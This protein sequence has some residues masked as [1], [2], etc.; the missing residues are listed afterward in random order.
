MAEDWRAGLAGLDLTRGS[1]VTVLTG[2][3]ISA[4]SGIPTFR[5]RDGLWKNYRAEELAT[6]EAFAA[7]PRLV[8][9]WYDWRRGIIA[10]KEPNPAHYAI[11]DLEKVFERFLLITQNVDGLHRRAGT[12][13]IVELHGYIFGVR[14]V[15][16]GKTMENLEVPLAS[17]PPLCECGAMLRPDI[18][19]FGEALPEQAI[20]KAIDASRACDLMLVVGTSAVVQPAASMPMLAREAGAFV[21]EINP[22]PTPLS[23]LVDIALQGKAGE[24]LP[25]VVAALSE[26]TS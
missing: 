12:R 26:I 7:D 25:E 17:I 19:W 14:C 18:V 20:L 16:E 11:T 22:D 21:L 5:G 8:W 9:E 6:P 15:A 2:A 1:Y 4:E 23:P 3:G 24:V 13:N 10:G